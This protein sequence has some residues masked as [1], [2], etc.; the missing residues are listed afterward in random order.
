M[1]YQ[2]CVLCLPFIATEVPF[3]LKLVR[4]K[5]VFVIL[6]YVRDHEIFEPVKIQVFA[7]TEKQDLK[8]C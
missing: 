3:W 8:N 6:N 1:L 4:Q 5:P 7:P 2:R